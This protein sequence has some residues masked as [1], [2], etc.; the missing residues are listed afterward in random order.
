ML[1]LGVIEEDF[2]QLSTT[3]KDPNVSNKFTISSPLPSHPLYLSAKRQVII[4][5]HSQ[6]KK[7]KKIKK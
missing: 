6:A 4:T 1:Y 2:D 7:I 3:W 5:N